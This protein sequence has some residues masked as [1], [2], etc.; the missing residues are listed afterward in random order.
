MANEGVKRQTAVKIK[1]SDLKESRY[2]KAT[3]E[4]EPNY[5]LTPYNTKV[6][7]VNLLGTVINEE[8]NN[9]TID[10]G[11]G[12]ITIRSFEEPPYKPAMGEVLTI[13]GRPREFSEE[14]YIVP[15]II[16]PITNNKEKWIEL[17]KLEL[18]K[19][20]KGMKKETPV[21]VPQKEPA[22]VQEQAP[23]NKENPEEP[24]S[25]AKE[26]AEEEV[27]PEQPAQTGTNVFDTVL[28][29]I[30]EID[31]GDGADME[32]IIENSGL[33]EKDVENVINNL[34]MDGEAFEIRPGRLKLLD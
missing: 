19:L 1:I 10:D 29:T 32:K 4:W 26:A 31:T 20:Y 13:I 6:S 9:F 22:P 18:D 14:T 30:K 16:K 33:D 15:E 8:E 21:E 2:V 5:I 27:V 28:N 34:L 7:R 23:N 3:G 12:N 24:V 17:R 25:P 11:S